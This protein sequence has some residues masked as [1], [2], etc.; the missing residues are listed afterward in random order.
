[1]LRKSDVKWWILEAEKHPESA[2][3]IIEELAR[4]LAELDAE[5][6]R[7]RDEIVRLQHRV[8]ASTST[9]SGETA[10]APADVR[11]LQ[12][13]V[14]RL[15][16]LLHG[17]ASDEA[18]LVLLSARLQA[19]RVPLS[20][21]HRL[22]REERPVLGQ[23][24]RLRLRCAVVAHPGE[25]L[26]L[27]TSQGRCLAMALSDVPPLIETGEDWPAG[28]TPVLPENERLTAAVSVSRLPR[29]WT[30][31]TRRGYVRQFLNLELQRAAKQGD[32]LLESPFPHDGPVAA[33]SGDRGDL[34]LFTRWGKCARFP[35]RAIES[36]GSSALALEP[37]DAVVTALSLPEAGEVALV[38]AAGFGVR[39]DV[40]QI[41][42]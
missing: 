11:A 37:D 27:F 5:N 15:Q 29:F 2:S 39:R 21:A 4:R 41:R 16:T 19:A 20:L 23:P 30:V 35:H 8:P 33:V 12:A 40:D 3:D 10:E 42:A 28:D 9:T 18:A 36:G 25:T 13:Q 7:L 14:D 38:T 1:M 32:V 17:D 6:E 22:A 34:L 24:A 31:A 26:L